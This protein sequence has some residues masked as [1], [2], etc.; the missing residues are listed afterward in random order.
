[1]QLINLIDEE[2][3]NPILFDANIVL[4]IGKEEYVPTVIESH[5]ANER[6]NC[7]EDIQKYWQDKIHNRKYKSNSYSL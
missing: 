2:L 4:S 1:L 5:L 3:E 7:L 6:S